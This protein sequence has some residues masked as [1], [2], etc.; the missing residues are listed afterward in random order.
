MVLRLET[1]AN[2]HLAYSL[3]ATVD[4]RQ[5]T[6]VP[7]LVIHVRA[8]QLLE[9]GTYGNAPAALEYRYCLPRGV[10]RVRCTVVLGNQQQSFLLGVVPSGIRLLGQKGVGAPLAE[11]VLR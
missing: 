9:A 8:L 1:R 2:L 11:L 10:D 4:V 3:R 7:E 5:T 6:E